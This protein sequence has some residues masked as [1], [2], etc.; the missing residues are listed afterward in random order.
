MKF[1]AYN[2]SNECYISVI[3]MDP[4]PLEYMCCKTCTVNVQALSRMFV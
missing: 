3:D 2:R 4:A 1:L